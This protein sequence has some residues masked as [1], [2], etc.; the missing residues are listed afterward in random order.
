MSLIPVLLTILLA[1]SDPTV[2]STGRPA[3]TALGTG[4]QIY[5][6]QKQAT[7][8]WVFH[9]P[10]ATLTAIGTGETLGTHSAGPT[11]TWK[12]GSSITG[13]VAQKLVASNHKDIP[14]LLL[15]AHSGSAIEGAFSPVIWIRRSD[16]QGGQAPATECDAEHAGTTVRV[17]Y[18]ATYTFFVSN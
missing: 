7:Y 11:W 16:T 17:P 6:C 9:A 10:E 13:K 5:A 12:D 4:V 2:P 8:I 15:E 14:W 3:L 1:A 18:H